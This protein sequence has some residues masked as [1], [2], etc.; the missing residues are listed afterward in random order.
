MIGGYRRDHSIRAERNSLY[1]ERTLEQYLT[2]R[3]EALKREARSQ[4]EQELR[5]GAD[6]AVRTEVGRLVTRLLVL[7]SYAF[8]LG[9]FSTPQ[10]LA[11]LVDPAELGRLVQVAALRLNAI[12]QVVPDALRSTVIGAVTGLAALSFNSVSFK[13]RFDLGGTLL[14][15]IVVLSILGCASAASTGLIGT[16]A[17]FLGLGG[18][19]YVVSEFFQ[20]LRRLDM[21]VP[22]DIRSVEADQS[23]LSRLTGQLLERGYATEL[24]RVGR[25]VRPER[26]RVGTLVFLGGPPISMAAMLGVAVADQAGPPGPILYWIFWSGL[27]T[28]LAWCLW[29]CAVTPSRV[30]IPLWSI[31]GWSFLVLLFV[32][33]TAVSAIFALATVLLLIAN[34]YVV[35]L[36]WSGAFQRLL[37]PGRTSP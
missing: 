36:G 13:V 37:S 9:A 15:G 12:I 16:T 21:H 34:L 2:L 33:F 29:A 35:V 5:A 19:L 25:I 32:F 28:L 17:F 24:H 7:A 31:V 27:M 4:S 10:L 14:V 30:R 26:S 6:A 18:S 1:L 20:V 8:V 11:T 3:I 23:V 22:S